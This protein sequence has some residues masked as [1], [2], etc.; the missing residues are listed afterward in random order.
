MINLGFEIFGFGRG[1]FRI[2]KSFRPGGKSK[3]G[4]GRKIRGLFEV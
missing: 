4:S 3:P 2:R 1:D